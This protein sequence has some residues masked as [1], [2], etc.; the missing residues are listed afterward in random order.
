MGDQDGPVNKALA[1]KPDKLS[2]TPRLHIVEGEIQLPEAGLWPLHICYSICVPTGIQA[3]T[4]N[5]WMDER[6]KEL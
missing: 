1:S 2:S 6:K 4:L 5:E 3:H